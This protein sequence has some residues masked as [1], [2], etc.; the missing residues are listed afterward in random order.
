MWTCD[1]VA[2]DIEGNGIPFCSQET[3]I[4]HSRHVHLFTVVLVYGSI[5][6]VPVWKKKKKKDRVNIYHQNILKSS[7]KFII[8]N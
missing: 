4:L 8:Y 6:S 5:T 1:S 2:L 3:I 7:D